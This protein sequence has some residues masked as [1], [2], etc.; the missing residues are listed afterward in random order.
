MG[1]WGT[2]S[3]EPNLPF[4]WARGLPSRRGTDQGAELWRGLTVALGADCTTASACNRRHR[5]CGRGWGGAVGA[6]PRRPRGVVDVGSAGGLGR[7]Q[8]GAWQVGGARSFVV[9]LCTTCGEAEGT[10][11]CCSWLRPSPAVATP[12]W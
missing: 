5:R 3:P 1:A 11:T 2:A 12:Q 10:A 6:C 9:E 8:H 4:A 7:G